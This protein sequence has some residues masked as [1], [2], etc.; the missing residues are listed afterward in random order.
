[1]ALAKLLDTKEVHHID[2][3]HISMIAGSKAKAL[4][5]QPF[6]VWVKKTEAL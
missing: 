4:V 5:W 1:M 2:A 3:G 6:S